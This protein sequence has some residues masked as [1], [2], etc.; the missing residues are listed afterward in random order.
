M[1]TNSK[2]EYQIFSHLLLDYRSLIKDL[3]EPQINHIYREGNIV[4]NKLTVF[5]RPQNQRTKNNVVT[6]DSPLPFILQEFLEDFQS[7]ETARI[8]HVC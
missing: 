1:G 8:G 4:A 6:F 7:N 5:G 3:N 2:R